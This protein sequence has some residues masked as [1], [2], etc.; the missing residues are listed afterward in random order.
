MGGDTITSCSIRRMGV[1][2]IGLC[3]CSVYKSKS[4]K[5][6]F[7]KVPTPINIYKKDMSVY[8]EYSCFRYIL[9]R[10]FA[11]S[12]ISIASGT[13]WVLGQGLALGPWA[14]LSI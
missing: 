2:R 1:R 13:G 7:T 9:K 11:I 6:R 8:I 14:P 12:P 4:M 10:R 5:N 3:I